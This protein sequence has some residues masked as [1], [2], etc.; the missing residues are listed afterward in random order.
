MNEKLENTVN[1]IL[2]KSIDAATQGAE[3]VK[4]QIPDL[5]KQLLMWHAA[6][7]IILV[8][9]MLLTLTL[10]LVSLKKLVRDIDDVF[11][12]VCSIVGGIVSLI[13]LIVGMHALFDLV[14]I[15]VAPKVWLLEYGANL[16][17]SR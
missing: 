10:A 8:V 11:W 6:R 9:M 2:Q 13:L 16:I 3:F 4:D 14:E 12:G 17:R 15:L 5:L 7:D 1:E